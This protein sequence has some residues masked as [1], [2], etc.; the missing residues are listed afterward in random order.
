MVLG[1]SRPLVFK[2]MMML[3]N[4]LSRYCDVLYESSIQFVIHESLVL[5][6]KVNLTRPIHVALF[7]LLHPEKGGTLREGHEKRARERGSRRSTSLRIW[8]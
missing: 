8:R 5:L 3:M 4:S 7:D 6:D 1:G 2:A